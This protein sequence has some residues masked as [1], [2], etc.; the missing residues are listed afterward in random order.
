MCPKASC[1]ETG[2]QAGESSRPRVPDTQLRSPRETQCLQCQPHL[3][4]RDLTK[5][6]GVKTPLGDRDLTQLLQTGPDSLGN[7]CFPGTRNLTSWKQAAAACKAPT[8][9]ER[10]KGKSDCTI[11]IQSD[12]AEPRG[13]PLTPLLLPG[14]LSRT[15]ELLLPVSLYSSNKKLKN[16]KY[17]HTQSL[18][19]KH[20]HL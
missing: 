10:Q 20:L 19:T 8:A 15:E 18:K 5:P 6:E 12:S 2:V 7:M 14:A 11:C 17:T 16:K 1:L 4:L 13:G 3:F 9:N